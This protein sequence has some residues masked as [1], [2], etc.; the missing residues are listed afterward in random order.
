[1]RDDGRLSFVCDEFQ[2]FIEGH[3]DTTN[4]HKVRC[5]AD[6]SHHMKNEDAS[7]RDSN[8]QKHAKRIL[9]TSVSVG[10]TPLSHGYKQRQTADDT[11]HQ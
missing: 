5:T 11:E 3:K 9:N 8:E 2:C 10:W 1:M 6:S 4:K 7:E